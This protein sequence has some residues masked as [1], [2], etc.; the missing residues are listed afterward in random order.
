MS[1]SATSKLKKLFHKTKSTDNEKND[2][3]HGDAGPATQGASS[4][5]LQSGLGAV[6]PRDGTI[7]GDILP[8]IQ[9]SDEKR[10][11]RFLSLMLKKKRRSTETSIDDPLFHNGAD[12]LESFSSNMSFDQISVSTE[13]CPNSTKTQGESYQDNISFKSFDMSALNSAP[14]S[15]NK[16]KNKSSDGMFNRIGS[17]FSS[18]RKKSR[19]NSSGGSD[20][21]SQQAVG[22]PVSPQSPGSSI[23]SNQ[24][25][26]ED[27]QRTPTATRRDV[28][29]EGAGGRAG[30]TQGSLSE[31]QAESS[32]FIGSSS[33]TTSSLDS[34]VVG[35]VGYMP[36]ADS[37]SSG[38]GSVMELQVSATSG[39]SRVEAGGEADNHTS[40]DLLPSGSKQATELSHNEDFMGEVK[41]K[42]QVHVEQ[43][44]GSAGGSPVAQTTLRSFELSQSHLNP[45]VTSL[46]TES[47]KT[48]LKTSVGGKT[49]YLVGVTL[50]SS[51]TTSSSDYQPDG[52][53]EDSQAPG[54]NTGRRA[55]KSISTSETTTPSHA[56][57]QDSPGQ[58]HK[59]LWVE[60]HMEEEGASL[61][62]PVK[63]RKVV[64]GKTHPGE[65]QAERKGE[66]E[67]AVLAVPGTAAPVE[68][69][70]GVPAAD[71]E[72]KDG[73]RVPKLAGYTAPGTRETETN[74]TQQE[75]L[76][77]GIDSELSPPLDDQTT[78]TKE[79]KRRSLKL[80]Q[81]ETF[82]TKKVYVSPEPS[83]DADEQTD[84]ELNKSDN[85]DL[86][87]KI[88][89]KSVKLLPSLKKVFAEDFNDPND[90]DIITSAE[91]TEGTHSPLN[92]HDCNAVDCSPTTPSIELDLTSPAGN[93]PGHRTQP[94]N[95]ASGSR[96]QRSPQVNPPNQAEE[97]GNIASHSK[98]PPPPVRPKS[99][100]VIAIGKGFA[101]GGGDA[102]ISSGAPLRRTSKDGFETTEVMCPTSKD[103]PT[104]GKT[105]V[106]DSSKSRI[107]KKSLNEAVP[108]ALPSANT[109][110]LSDVLEVV[111][112][113]GS[114]PQKIPKPK[115]LT[116]R[117]D[118]K[119]IS[120]EVK[121]VSPTKVPVMSPSSSKDTEDI[122]TMIPK[123]SEPKDV[124][125]QG[126]FRPESNNSGV[127][128]K[129]R[130]PK[131]TDPSSSPAVKK[132]KDGKL[133]TS[134]TNGKKC[135]ITEKASGA[136]IQPS[137]PTSP[138]QKE[139]PSP[140]DRPTDETLETKKESKR[141]SPL[142][143]N[144]D[145]TPCDDLD[146]P[147]PASPTKTK[148][149]VSLRL[150]KQSNITSPTI[151][152]TAEDPGKLS[153]LKLRSP[154]KDQSDSVTVASKLP[155]F[156]QKTPP[157][158][159]LNNP[160]KQSD[161]TAHLPM[162]K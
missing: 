102:G 16:S 22:T 40:A 54:K 75:D 113:D 39:V 149:P 114:R 135:Q 137:T 160:L 140:E 62:P 162:R 30:R 120:E 127:V 5:R 4:E 1:K 109:S 100:N 52:E 46:V 86:E 147:T 134:D 123:N 9:A 131:A 57:T 70:A 121:M 26:E 60:T 10:R 119:P 8:T 7:S 115:H 78:L 92:H 20:D 63:L 41:K 65:E 31:L 53:G 37:D 97:V 29:T 36:F 55:L 88:P 6:S 27:V 148:K 50:V 141:P 77:P 110:S 112:F 87:S 84:R 24:G 43:T 19:S 108:K 154:V 47:K 72:V 158:R 139:L 32:V 133:L 143:T 15:P 98:G 69:N 144:N 104:T 99:K 132:S 73:G 18:K 13:Y 128:P 125:K 14:L 96:G 51:R 67:L 155:L 48:S 33:P 129:S 124:K 12:E 44:T 64:L 74:I 61:D 89:L 23:F 2:I 28:E 49:S 3:L 90:D 94:Y 91:I 103:Q 17:F 138:K 35:D 95:R 25:L 34:L 101:G 56:T 161:Q 122:K 59:A 93:M 142:S 107:P 116:M 45:D 151:D 79:E 136:S 42:L 76:S 146:P 38:R 152:K 11:R 81:S 150:K 82:F 71:T 153:P 83:I 80:S 68:Y 111:S 159:K 66:K 118:K 145:N 156:R 58:I 126:P 85:I 21:G 105:D 117:T 130:L 157:K 106:A